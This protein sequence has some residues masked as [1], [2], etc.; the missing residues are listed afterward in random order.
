MKSRENGITNHTATMATKDKK[1]YTAEFVAEKLAKKGYAF[2]RLTPAKIS[3]DASFSETKETLESNVFEGVFDSVSAAISVS[4][5]D[6]T[7]TYLV[8]NDDDAYDG[9][10]EVVASGDSGEVRGAYITEKAALRAIVEKYDLVDVTDF[11]LEFSVG[12]E[13]VRV[14]S[15]GEAIEITS[16]SGIRYDKYR[17][18]PVYSLASRGEAYG[19]ELRPYSKPAK[20]SKK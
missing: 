12:D 15:N 3:K 9:I 19:P 7:R 10:K 1:D 8:V 13:V 2:K 4:D 18:A 6:E 20:T 5:E 14:G 16:V 17:K 11:E